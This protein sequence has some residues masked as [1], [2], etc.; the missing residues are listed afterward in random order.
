VSPARE[1]WQEGIQPGEDGS[2]PAM[3][4]RPGMNQD[5]EAVIPAREATCGPGSLQSPRRTP[6]TWAKGA[7]LRAVG[8]LWLCCILK[9]ADSAYLP[10][11]T[12]PCVWDGSG[13]PPFPCLWPGFGDVVR[14]SGFFPR[15]GNGPQSRPWPLGGAHIERGRSW[16]DR[17]GVGE[18]QGE[19][20]PGSK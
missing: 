14:S 1:C 20:V 5:R 19:D 6:A 2:P 17:G 13:S 4:A 11:I 8:G 9:A 7:L 12:H 16:P 3:E 10:W 18:R 15:V